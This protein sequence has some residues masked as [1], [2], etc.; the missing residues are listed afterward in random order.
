M[1]ALNSYA[2][3]L[4][5]GVQ[6]CQWKFEQQKCLFPPWEKD[7]TGIFPVPGQEM[8]FSSR[9]LKI[10]DFFWPFFAENGRE[11]LKDPFLVQK[12]GGTFFLGGVKKHE[13]GVGNYP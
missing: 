9:C 8:E 7:T 5:L 13:L 12:I 11:G 3:T 6:S 1:L 2:L 4:R 10:L